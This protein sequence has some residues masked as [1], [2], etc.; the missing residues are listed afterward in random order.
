[1]ACELLKI[2]WAAFQKYVTKTNGNNFR[3]NGVRDDRK[4]I[5]LKIIDGKLKQK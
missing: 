5:P 3:N 2:N 4:G 1:M